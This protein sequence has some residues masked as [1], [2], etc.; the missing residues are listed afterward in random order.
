MEA[1]TLACRDVERIEECLF[2]RGKSIENSSFAPN[3]SVSH[4]VRTKMKEFV[5]A[6]RCRELSSMSSRC[7]VNSVWNL[8]DHVVEVE[9]GEK[10]YVSLFVA[11]KL[12]DASQRV[13]KRMRGV[14]PYAAC[15][16]GECSG[17]DCTGKLSTRRG[18]RDA[19]FEGKFSRREHH[20]IRSREKLES[21][22]RELRG[23][24]ITSNTAP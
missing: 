12:R 14:R 8:R 3:Y 24:V 15:D 22:S 13:E 6:D 1:A 2:R 17:A 5:R 11:E 9:S 20:E 16:R 19:G 21:H 18:H 10:R 23:R 7:H 4:H